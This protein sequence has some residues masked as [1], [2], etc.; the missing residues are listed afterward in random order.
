MPKTIAYWDSYDR[1]KEVSLRSLA[2]R[3]KGLSDCERIGMS[4]GCGADCIV[5]QRG[6]C[7]EPGEI[8]GAAITSVVE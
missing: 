1:E 4:D 7:K 6:E 5:Y 8:E 3:N 2:D